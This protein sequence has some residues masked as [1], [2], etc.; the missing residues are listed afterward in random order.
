M[1]DSLLG[2]DP[3]ELAVG[4]E[5]APGLAPVGS[6]LVQVF[7][8]D[9]RCDELNGGADNLIAATNC[10]CLFIVLDYALIVL[11][12]L[13]CTYHAVTA[14]VRVSVDNAVGRGVIAGSVHGIGAGLVEGGL[15]TG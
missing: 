6:Q 4:D 15:D 5:V 8:N 1:D 7:S 9:K 10:E 11:S 12:W 14:E 13:I 3:A 2:T